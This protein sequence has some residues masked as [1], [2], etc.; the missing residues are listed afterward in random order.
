MQ[1]LRIV[2]IWQNES[3]YS[4]QGIPTIYSLFCLPFLG[5]NALSHLNPNP[6]PNLHPNPN[7][8]PVWKCISTPFLQP[9]GM[10]SKCQQGSEWIR[11]RECIAINARDAHTV[12]H[13]NKMRQLNDKIIL[14]LPSSL[15]ILWN[16]CRC[17]LIWKQNRNVFISLQMKTELPK[18]EN[19]WC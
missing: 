12:A 15:S 7:C 2:L 17:H 13:W 6:N 4:S 9:T 5:A 16:I 14:T 1:K 3:T 19:P 18:P 11:D 8:N 10:G